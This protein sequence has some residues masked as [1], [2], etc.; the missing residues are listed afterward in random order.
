MRW[1]AFWSTLL[2]APMVALVILLYVE[3]QWDTPVGTYPF[4]F[5]VVSGTAFAAL[6]ACGVIVALIQTMR[7]TRLLFLGIAFMSIAGV[8]M[9]HGLGTPGHFHK[10]IHSELSVSSWLSVMAGA[11]FIALSVATLPPKIDEILKRHGGLVFATMALAIG[12]YIGLS[13]AAPDWTSFIP[14]DQRWVQLLSTAVTLSLLGFAAYRYFQ[15][16]LFARLPSQW[17]M[18]CILV[19]LMEV[20]VSM[21]W[22]HFWQ[23]SW[24]LYHGIYAMGFVILF[25][26]WAYEVKRAG[27]IRVLADGLAMRDAVAQLN[28]GYSQP[29][30]E[31]VDAI[32]WKD[33]YTHGHVRRVASYAVMMGKELGL[34]SVELRRLALGAQ[35]H[36]VGKI[37][38]PDRILKKAGPLTD[39]EFATIKKHATRGYEIAQQ[40][41]ALQPASDA[42]F[43]HHERFDGLGYPLGL[44]GEEIPLHARI[45]SVADAFDAMTSGRAYQPA[46]NHEAALTELRRCAGTHFD[47]LC[48]EAFAL[49]LQRLDEA[50]EE[51]VPDRPAS[52]PPK[53]PA[54][55]LEQPNRTAA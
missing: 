21:T 32:E 7:E 30:A 51:P 44:S 42:I 6:I 53:P 1:W 25:A 24:W 46:V 9:V 16:F 11:L 50:S 47:T 49:V 31:L 34:S 48:V 35:M 10:T 27:N 38:V 29:I 45:V 39:E 52:L 20:Q 54:P 23:I 4:H 12:I 19:L 3:P 41:T 55:V 33:L 37:G 5:Y 22:G 13:F 17:A 26:S 14:A 36:D 15:G 28:H 8:F 40:V 18:V 2:A 43:F